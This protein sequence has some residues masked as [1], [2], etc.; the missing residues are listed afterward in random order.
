[1]KSLATKTRLGLLAVLLAVVF[2]KPAS[3]LRPLLA[4][5]APSPKSGVK[6]SQGRAKLMESYGALP[7]RFEA[8][9]GQ[10]DS[11]V[12]FLSRGN[13]YTLFLTG[14]EAVLALRSQKPEVR[15]QN[16]KSGQWSVVGGQSGR[17]KW[18]VV[19]RNGQGTND[20]L[21]MKLVGA[22][23]SAKVTALDALSGKSNY[24]IGNDPQKWRTNVPNYARVSYNEVY[25]GVDLVYYGNQGQLEYDFVV[26]PGVDPK[27]ITLSVAA[28]SPPSPGAAM[29]TSPLHVAANGDLVIETASGEVCLHEPVVY[30]EQEP[31]GRSRKAEAGQGPTDNGPRTTDD[32]NRKSKIENLKL[33]DGRYVLTAGNRVGFEIAKYDKTKPLVIDPVLVYST[34]LGGS[35]DDT[36]AAIAVDAS[37]NAYVT[38]STAST[39]FPTATPIQ[40]SLAPS[41]NNCV[42]HASYGSRTVPCPDAFV[43]KLNATGTAVLY[44]TYL[45]GSDRDGASGIAVDSSGNAYIT[46]ETISTDFP[47]TAGAYHT[48]CG[49]DGACNPDANGNKQPDAFVAKL[50]ATGDALVFST[51]LGGSGWDS[52][53]G[54]ALDS[55]GNAYV[56]GATASSDFPTANPFQKALGGAGAANAFVSELNSTGSALIYSTY[57][58]G[59]VSDAASAVAVDSSGSAY[60][61]G[62]TFSPDFPTTAGAFDTSCGTDGACNPDASGNKQPDAFVAKLDPSGSK[63]LYSTYLGGSGIDGANG[64][65]V[66]SSGNAYVTGTT[67]STDFPTQNPLQAAL[68]GGYDAFVTKLNP[69]GSALVYSTYLGGALNDLGTGIALDSSADAY[70]TGG[71][72]SSD[73]PTTRPLQAAFGGNE[74]AF[75]A[76]LNPTGATLAYSTYLGGSG[77]DGGNG[78]AVDSSGNAFATGGTISGFP[79]SLGSFMTAPGGGTCL[80]VRGGSGNRYFIS[81]PCADAFVVKIGV[82]DAPGFAVDQ[83]GLNFAI[84]AV[85]TSTTQAINLLDAGSQPL[86]ISSVAI[87]GTNA[88]DFSETTTCA[89]T[90]AMIAGGTSCPV[91]VTFAPQTLGTKNATLVI[92]DDAAGSP[93]SI[94]LTGVSATPPTA[95][96]S[97]TSLTFGSEAVGSSSPPQTITLTNTG[98]APLL[99]SGISLGP[100]F[101]L[102]IPPTTVQCD[103]GAATLNGGSSCTIA[104]SFIPYTAGTL[105]EALTIT[106]NAANSPQT[107]ALS[108]TGLADFSIADNIGLLSVAPGGTGSFNAIITP[109]GGFNQAVVLACSGTPPLPTALITCQV[110]PSSVTPDGT[111]TSTALVTLTTTAPTMLVPEWPLGPHCPPPGMPSRWLWLMAL[112]MLVVAATGATRRF[113]PQPAQ[114]RPARFGVAL[115]LLMVLAWAACGASHRPGTPPGTYTL[116]ITGTSGSLTHSFIQTLAVGQ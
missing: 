23:Q 22:N 30:Q 110:S 75:V 58:G 66:D 88:G 86:T 100:D 87:T 56:T 90:P 54:I 115:T 45:G 6:A 109:L 95:T 82:T 73:F 60:V 67:G 65:A 24:F 70:V 84:Q 99:I 36:G 77:A 39:D 28:A 59:S 20:V 38:G 14:S 19:S 47:T 103:G 50:N 93:H 31:G 62:G 83:S 26:A 17:T 68:G 3:R 72:S 85:S 107:V 33:I 104:V 1:M 113:G 76:K 91:S 63:L 98:G 80:S 64:I 105:N 8:N 116:T 12:K 102:A 94:S 4:A 10:A 44:S 69:A 53:N 61:T 29:R 21:R 89:L 5:P 11:H 37:G 9:Q 71:T 52:A 114:G 18:P 43:T 97:A 112:S 27:A 2:A 16:D 42:L 55:S 49:T 96:L 101:G 108:G 79:V 51:Y 34:Y 13:G 15:S 92:A 46:G 32:L 57:L 106:D 40:A 35:G 48:K 81:R 74:D 78:I 41:G 111:N 7:L 25:P